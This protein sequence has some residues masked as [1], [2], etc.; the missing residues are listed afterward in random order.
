MKNESQQA[1]LLLR[2][3]LYQQTDEQHPVSVTDIL[4]FWQLHGIQA[5]RK[6]VYTDIELLQNAGMDIVCVKSSQ[7]K[8]FVGQ[9]LFELP[10][11]KLLVDAVESSRF[12]TEKKSTALI[13][14]LGHLTS[15]AQAEQL[16]RRIY[17]GGTPKPENESI[18]YNVD[19]IHNAVQKKQQIT[20]QYF[21][22]TP[23]KEKILKHDGYK[24]RFSP[25]AMIWNRDCYYAVGWSEKHGK[26][27]Q[28]RVDR[29]TAVEPLEQTAV[30]TL[31][32]DPAEYVRKVFGMYPDN[33][34]T[35]ELLCDNEI[36]RSVIDRF[37]ENVQTETV[38]EQHF[39]ATVEVAPSP[40]FF[41]WVFTFSGKIRIVSPA[42]VLEEMRD[43]AAWLK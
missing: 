5:G 23:K 28:F 37:G 40:P 30:Q 19:T 33:L 22:Y 26:I 11:L 24:Y 16:N 15:T 2:Q 12:I 35:V 43:M 6:S 39:R 13:K 25:Y 32:F 7:N 29:M 36:M 9:R 20:F 14:K 1:L 31:D 21:E 41:S 4:A 34:C 27:A 42:A 8:Y 10:E 38:D 18:Y 3:Y 17:M